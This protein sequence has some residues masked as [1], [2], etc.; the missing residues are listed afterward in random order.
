M[1]W[2]SPVSRV[3]NWSLIAKCSCITPKTTFFVFFFVGEGSY[4]SQQAIQSAY[5]KLCRETN[6]NINN[7]VFIRTVDLSFKW[8]LLCIKYLVLLYFFSL[9]KIF[10]FENLFCWPWMS[11]FCRTTTAYAL[12]SSVIAITVWVD[13]PRPGQTTRNAVWRWAW[14]WLMPFGK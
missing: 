5:S 6:L 13:C 8:Y 11:S 10:V 1:K 2:Y 3:Q 7:S 12:K 14:T 9:L 4:P